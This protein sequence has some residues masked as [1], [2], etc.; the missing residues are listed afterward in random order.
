[1]VVSEKMRYRTPKDP[2]IPLLDICPK[3]LKVGTQIAICTHICST[4]AITRSESNPS[5]H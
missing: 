2:A 4:T 3:G 5:D 1:M